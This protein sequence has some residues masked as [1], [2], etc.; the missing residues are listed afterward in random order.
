M[1]ENEQLK[2]SL[3]SLN[4]KYQQ[5]ESEYCNFDAKLKDSEKI[6]DD[7]IESLALKISKLETACESQ[8]KDSAVKSL[9]IQELQTQIETSNQNASKLTED[10]NALKNELDESQKSVSGLECEIH[11]IQSLNDQ[12]HDEIDRLE[13]RL[14]ENQTSIQEEIQARINEQKNGYELMV[15]KIKTKTHNIYSENKVIQI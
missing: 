4:D 5:L 3:N 10:V 15:H 9:T 14:L 11:R 7:E 6:K 2:K 1:F 12:L 13:Q 8:T